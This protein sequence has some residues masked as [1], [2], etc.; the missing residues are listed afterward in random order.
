M[1]IIIQQKLMFQNAQMSCKCSYHLIWTLQ[2]IHVLLNHVY[3]LIHWI[4]N[5]IQKKVNKIESHLL[6]CKHSLFVIESKFLWFILQIDH[7]VQNLFLIT[8]KMSRDILKWDFDVAN[9]LSM[10]FYDFVMIL[11]QKHWES[12]LLQN[13]FMMISFRHHWHYENNV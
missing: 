2:C 9:S 3:I 4:F 13:N 7:A 6:S 5:W 1:L 10:F 12:S 11:L 8:F